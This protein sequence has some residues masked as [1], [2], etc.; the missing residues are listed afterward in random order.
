MECPFSFD[1]MLVAPSSLLP[2]LSVVSSPVCMVTAE[3]TVLGDRQKPKRHKLNRQSFKRDEQ[4]RVGRGTF[5]EPCVEAG[6]HGEKKIFMAS[7]FG[8]GES[9]A[10]NGESRIELLLATNIGS[11]KH[12]K[13]E[14]KVSFNGYYKS[15]G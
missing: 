3:K 13:G 2:T 15:C 9:V 11:I 8:L 12:K 1:S 10:C 7:P 6:L 5:G 14:G 4:A